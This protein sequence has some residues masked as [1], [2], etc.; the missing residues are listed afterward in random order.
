MNDHYAKLRNMYL[1]APS[2]QPYEGLNI[3]IRE[4]EATVRVQAVEAMHHAAGAVHG[5]FYFKLLDDAA[6]FA[7]N[8]LVPDV[9]V[10]TASFNIELHRPVSA[11][12]LRAE[13][14]VTKPGRTILFAASELFDE[15]GARVG[16]GSG[17]FARSKV[18]LH[19]VSSYA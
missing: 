17:T 16:C 13:G 8:A 18:P 14:R 5:S 11:G 10:L 7:C 6:F 4:G 12:V 9:F 1:S 2:N 3:D 15:A 19:E